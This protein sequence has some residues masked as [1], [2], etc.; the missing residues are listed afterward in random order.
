[1]ARLLLEK[2]D[3]QLDLKAVRERFP[4]E[5][6]A[7]LNNI[8]NRE[9]AAFARLLAAI[10]ASVEDLLANLDGTCPR[11]LEVEALWS[12]VRENRVPDA[13]RRVSFPTARECLADFLAALG[14][15]LSFWREFVE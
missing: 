1:M 8:I 11:P 2:M 5:Y 7:P 13:W 6:E 9:L 12:R 10:R 15:K 3:A 14:F 4:L